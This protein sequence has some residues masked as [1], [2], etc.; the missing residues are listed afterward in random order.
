MKLILIEISIICLLSIS[1]E[2]NLK[3]KR[4]LKN[5]DDCL[6][7][8]ISNKESVYCK[9]DLAKNGLENKLPGIKLSPIAKNTA[10]FAQDAKAGIKFYNNYVKGKEGNDAVKFEIV[11]KKPE[12]KEKDRPKNSIKIPNNLG[13][14]VY[15]KKQ[16]VFAHPSDIYINP[17]IDG[18]K[19]EFRFYSSPY[20]SKEYNKTKKEFEEAGFLSEPK[21]Y[22]MS[23]SLCLNLEKIEI[24]Y[25]GE[26]AMS[27]LFIHK[28]GDE[29][30]VDD[31]H[32]V[33]KQGDIT[34]LTPGYKEEREKIKGLI[35]PMKSIGIKIIDFDTKKEIADKY[36]K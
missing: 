5:K 35:N 33:I 21:D 34:S 28:K 2:L 17:S 11:Y 18:C 1:F 24:V 23:N 15:L 19:F 10:K 3:R 4:V 14:Y 22:S 8:I 12:L 30:R 13:M 7:I 20:P 29:F 25:K 9:E 6:K 27:R 32:F 16:D 31:Y 36:L 26:T